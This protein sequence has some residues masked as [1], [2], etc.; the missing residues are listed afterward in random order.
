MVKKLELGS[1][2]YIHMQEVRVRHKPQGQIRT[3]THLKSA[4]L[5]PN[6]RPCEGIPSLP[7]ALPLRLADKPHGWDTVHENLLKFKH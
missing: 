6:L 1:R 2:G 3:A 7:F 5:H 4:F